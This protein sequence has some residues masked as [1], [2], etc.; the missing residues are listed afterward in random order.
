MKLK[1]AEETYYIKQLLGFEI[2]NNKEVEHAKVL[3][4]DLESSMLLADRGY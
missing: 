4:E 2:E 3:L 1:K